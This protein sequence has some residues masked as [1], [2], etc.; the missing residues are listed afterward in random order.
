[1][2]GPPPDYVEV[3][4]RIVQF[5]EMYPEG[6]LQ[7][8]IVTMTDSMVVVK[9]YAY[10]TA[11][12]TRPG[13]GLASEPIPGKTNFTRDSELMNCETSAWGRA[14]IAVGA[15][16]AKKGIA[17]ANEVR[18]RSAVP[19]HK[20]LIVAHLNKK[21]VPLANFKNWLGTQGYESWDAVEPNQ[22]SAIA[23]GITR[24]V[25]LDDVIKAA[26]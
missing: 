3:K 10:R 5:R 9:A 7:A 1:M 25:L 8:E 6:T 18:N 23:D 26:G 12:D 2:S 4:D 16:D 13:T 17:S 14:I 24:G 19:D 15:A 22:R 11:D 21:K 20:A